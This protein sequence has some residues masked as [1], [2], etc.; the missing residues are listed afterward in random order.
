MYRALVRA[1]DAGLPV[2]QLQRKLWIAAS[3]LSHPLHRLIQM[4]LVSQERRATMIICRANCNAMDRLIR[5]LVD[6]C[7]ADAAFAG[8]EN[9]AAA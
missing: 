2:A 1:D 4:G 5:F 7:C 3:T 6:E 9:E 8:A